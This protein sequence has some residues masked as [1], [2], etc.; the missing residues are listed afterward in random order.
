MGFMFPLPICQLSSFFKAMVLDKK[1]E[2]LQH[3]NSSV[4]SG[5]SLCFLASQIAL[6]ALALWRSELSNFLGQCKERNPKARRCSESLTPR[7]AGQRSCYSKISQE[8]VSQCFPYWEHLHISAH[9]QAASMVF[10]LA[11]SG[12]WKSFGVS[13]NCLDSG[14]WLFRFLPV[15]TC[16]RDPVWSRRRV[17]LVFHCVSFSWL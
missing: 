10:Q 16:I 6:A 5:S 11:W 3:E 8:W 9:T 7:P 17:T 4:D 14:G 2:S 1:A 15:A 12:L 13:E